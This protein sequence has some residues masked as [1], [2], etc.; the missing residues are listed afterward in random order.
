[1]EAAFTIVRERLLTI[2]GKL[3]DNLVAREREEIEDALREEIS[4]ALTELHEPDEHDF[5]SRV[6][7]AGGTS[8]D[9]GSQTALDAH[10]H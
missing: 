5:R 2:P 1:M 7:A 10:T 9:G 4:D 6:A 8:G 3:A